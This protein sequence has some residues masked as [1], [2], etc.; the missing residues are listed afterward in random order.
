MG[1]AAVMLLRPQAVAARLLLLLLQPLFLLLKKDSTTES[2][3]PR[4]HAI[5]CVRAKVS[6]FEAYACT[7]SV[8]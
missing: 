5:R 6:A 3:A 8:H 7:H 4:A 2:L 1:S